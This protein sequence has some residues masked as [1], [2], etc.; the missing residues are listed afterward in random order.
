MFV[1][2]GAPRAPAAELPRDQQEFFEKRIRPMLLEHCVSCHGAETQ[3]AGLRL[4]TRAFMM[5]G[6]DGAP[7]A[8][9]GQPDR[10]RLIEVTRYDGSVQMPPD[11]KLSED[12]FNMLVAW[13]KMGLPWPDHGA[14]EPTADGAP[15]ADPK[16]TYAQSRATHWAFQPTRKPS[17]PEV[18]NAAWCRTPIDRFIVAALESHDLQPSAPADRR[19]LL[20]RLSFDLT[21]LPPAAAE[22]EAFAADKSPEAVTH[23][24]ERLLSSPAYGERWARHWLDVARYA[25]T[26][27]YVATEEPRYPYA[28]TYRDY[29]IGA[30]NADKPYNQFVLEQLAADLLPDQTDKSR[31]AALGYLTVGRRFTNNINDII[32]D[33]IDVVGR[34]LMGLTVG[35]ARCHDHKYDPIPTDDYYSLYGVFASCTEPDDLPQIGEPADK[36]AFADYQKEL[37]KRTQ[38]LHDYHTREVGELQDELRTHVGDY[39]TLVWKDHRK[40]EGDK[41]ADFRFEFTRGEPRPQIAR[42]WSDYLS[43]HTKLFDPVFSVWHRYLSLPSED[44][45]FAASAE[46]ILTELSAGP[47]KDPKKPVN[48]LLRQAFVAAKPKTM[49]DVI[50]TYDQALHTVYDQWKAATDSKKADAP[51]KRDDPAAEQLRQ[52]LFGSDSPASLEG[53][54]A[55]A[56]F[57]RKTRDGQTKLERKI[58]NLKVTSPGAPPRAMVLADSP[59]PVQPAVF[60]RGNPGRRGKQIPRQF[61]EVIAGPQRK[62]FAQGSGRLEMAQAIVDPS[63]PLTARVIV[64]RVWMHHFGVGLVRTASD[65]GIRGEAPTH[66]E[67]LD[68]L[69]ATFVEQGWSLKKLH[70]I[71]VASAVY[72]QASVDNPQRAGRDPENQWL[73]RMNRKRLEFEP[74]R[75]TMLTVAGRL[76]RQMGGRPVDLN[77]I[78]AMG[79]RTIYGLIDR[80]DMPAMLQAFDFPS[81]DTSNDQRPTT[82]VPQQA[83]FVMNSPLALE[84]A[85]SLAVRPEVQA[86]KDPGDKVRVLFELALSRKP[87][88]DET[89]RAEAFLAKPALSVA[90]EQP[91]WQ[92]GYGPWDVEQKRIAEFH[93]L[94]HWTGQRWQG[95]PKLHDPAIGYCMLS[96][97]GGH[98]GDNAKHCTVLRW[99]AR[100]DGAVKITGALVHPEKDKKHG[101]GVEARIV[102]S[103]TGQ[104]GSWIA[105][106]GAVDTVAERIELKRGDHID[107]IT[108]CRTGP[109]YDSYNWSPAIDLIDAETSLAWRANEMFHGPRPPRLSPWEMLAQV[110]LLTNEFTFID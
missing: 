19:T 5:K 59:K 57:D 104:V 35:C 99:T 61:L 67:L 2:F 101:D 88:A 70:Q 87:T 90:P 38:E 9:A 97:T 56:L 30:F 37:A 77:A 22:V 68:W 106:H 29:V 18:K 43:R 62:P 86:A 71:I 58:E 23:A 100:Q 107:F 32:D 27:G 98:P 36:T 109:S 102:A 63:N 42:R 14:P 13:V 89:K 76:D 60:I 20:R 103:G 1:A 34:G 44:E 28:Y 47:S 73:W 48:E 80:Q 45:K 108:D 21:G 24:V 26:K 4:D 40:R 8:V 39:L 85:R 12:D 81:P 55:T 72:Q 49:P 84:M 75:D 83:L 6:A 66:P 64:N 17:V 69:A 65:F 53:V 46:K 82:T 78:P 51:T 92:Y 93:P 25:D 54:D 110:L 31:L 16:T 33:R 50:K 94:P 10:S 105:E 7:A 52:V 11:G 3:E 74:L 96:A 79:R 15:A 91:M 95:G 41:I